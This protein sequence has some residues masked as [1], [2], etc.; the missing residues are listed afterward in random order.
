METCIKYGNIASLGIR[1]KIS[2][3]EMIISR[4]LIEFFQL[5]TKTI[6][7]YRGEIEG[8]NFFA[9]FFIQG[10]KRGDYENTA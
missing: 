10:R 7:I 1:T 2:P 9:S 8:F 5:L 3:L 6:R 4:G